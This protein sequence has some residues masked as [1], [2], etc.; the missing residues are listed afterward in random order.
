M[1]VFPAKTQR[2]KGVLSLSFAPLRLCGAKLLN[3]LIALTISLSFIATLAPI[4][5]AS[6]NKSNTMPCCVGKEAGHCESEIPAKKIPPAETEPMCGLD[7]AASED[8][9]ITIVAEPSQ[10][11]S[12]HSHSQNAEFG[13]THAETTSSESAAESATL[14]QPCHTDCCAC[15]SGLARN[16]RDRGTPHTNFRQGSASRNLSRFEGSPLLFLS[17]GTWEQTSPRGPPIALL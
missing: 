14:S 11:E 17:N 6:A 9:G 13:L 10:K 7:T 16:L 12:H 8:E 3:R 4:A 2:R 1:K 5:I 15:V